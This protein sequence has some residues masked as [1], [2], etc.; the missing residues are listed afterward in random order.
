MSERSLKQ[1]VIQCSFCET[2]SLKA[3]ISSCI[4]LRIPRLIYCF[5]NINP[6]GVQFNPA[7][8]AFIA[9]IYVG[10]HQP[11]P[12]NIPSCIAIYKH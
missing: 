10:N 3:D 8:K 4:F 11:P 1:A 12:A 6:L 5:E 9:A 7:G 2:T